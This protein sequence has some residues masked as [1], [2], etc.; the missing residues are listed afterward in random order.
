LIRIQTSERRTWG[1]LGWRQA[2]PAQLGPFQSALEIDSNL[3]DQTVVPFEQV[4]N[5][6]QQRV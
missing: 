6:R 2:V 4:G 3:L 5:G 1:D